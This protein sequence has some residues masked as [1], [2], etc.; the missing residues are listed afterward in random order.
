MTKKKVKKREAPLLDNRVLFTTSRGVT[1]ECMPVAGAL[2]AIEANIR[3]SIDWPELPTR[4][5]TD[6][7]G[8][9]MELPL[10]Q[11]YVDGN[12]VADEQKESWADYIIAQQAAQ[13]EFN[14]RHSTGLAKLLA[15]EGFK[16]LNVEALQAKWAEEDEWL[17]MTIPE[18]ERDR[19]YHFFQT[20]VL[21]NADTDVKGIATGVFRAS[22]YS[23]EVLDEYERR[24]RA[25]LGQPEDGDGTGEDQGDTG[26]PGATQD[27]LVGGDGLHGSASEES[28][29]LDG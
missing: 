27:G 2:E 25:D 14:T 1:G 3:N 28:A 21:G 11:E 17:E 18:G 23:R 8:S 10:T 13:L 7:A 6:V 16:P 20:R 4:T 5:I 24:F 26:T 22:G 19:A 12:E 9:E 15:W 29:G